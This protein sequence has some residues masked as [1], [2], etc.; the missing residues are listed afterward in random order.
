VPRRRKPKEERLELRIRADFKAALRAKAA[1]DKMSMTEYCIRTLSRALKYA[2]FW[3]PETIEEREARRLEYL[4]LMT[5]ASKRKAKGS[6]TPRKGKGPTPPGADN[7]AAKDHTPT[8]IAGGKA[9]GSIGGPRGG[10]PIGDPRRLSG[11]FIP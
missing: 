6:T 4:Q 10:R 8:P 1:Y 2:G 11:R 9:G 5:E 3:P 7:P